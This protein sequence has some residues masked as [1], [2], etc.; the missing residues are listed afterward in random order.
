MNGSVMTTKKERLAN[1]EINK[2][3]VTYEMENGKR[4]KIKTYADGTVFKYDENNNEIYYKGCDGYEKWYEY[5]ADGKETHTWDNRGY[6]RWLDYDSN[7]NE[8][9]TWD[10][11][12]YEDWNEYDAYR[13]CIHFKANNG[14]EWFDEHYE[15]R[16]VC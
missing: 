8:I 9:H 11:R 10:N 1:K 14:I 12:G 15:G 13:I 16:K 2:M 5:V 3:K 4:V 7:G 6:E